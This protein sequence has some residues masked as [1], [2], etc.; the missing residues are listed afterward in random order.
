MPTQERV[1]AFLTAEFPNVTIAGDTLRFAGLGMSSIELI[2]L[3]VGLERE[4]KI[5]FSLAEMTEKTFG[6]L[7]A[8]SRLVDERSR[9]AP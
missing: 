4:F 5:R 6:S 1:R 7:E 3:A 2:E 8:I 9:T